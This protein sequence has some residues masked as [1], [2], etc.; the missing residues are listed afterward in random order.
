MEDLQT[1]TL[2]DYGRNQNLESV[3]LDSSRDNENACAGSLLNAC[4]EIDDPLDLMDHCDNESIGSNS[5]VWKG[6]DSEDENDENKE[7]S[8]DSVESSGNVKNDQPTNPTNEITDKQDTSKSET[9]KGNKCDTENMCHKND[10]TEDCVKSTSLIESEEQDETQTLALENES[11]EEEKSSESKNNLNQKENEDIQKTEDS[12]VISEQNDVQDKTLEDIADLEQE[13]SANNSEDKDQLSTDLIETEGAKDPLENDAISKKSLSTDAIDKDSLSPVVTDKD[14]STAVVT[15]KDPLTAVVTDKDPSAAVVTNKDPLAAVVTDKG[16]LAAVVTDKDPLTAVVTDKDPLA[17]VVTNKDPLTAV[18]AD[19]DPLAAVATDKDPLT[20]V[21]TDEDPLS[22][23]ITE[24]DPLST[25]ITERDPLSINIED[26]DS[27]PIDDSNKEPLENKNVDVEGEEQDD[28]SQMDYDNDED[29]DFDPLL[30]CPEVSMAVD[31]SPVVTNNTLTL[32]DAGNDSPLPYEPLF[33]TF[34]DEVTG[35]EISFNL[36]SE[37][38]ELKKRLYGPT[39]PIQITRIHCTACNVHLGSA[40]E[41]QNNRFV[42][43]MLK[44]LICKECYHFYTSGEFE[45]DEDGSEL[46][47]RWCGQG[48]QVLC[49]SK[50]EFVFCKRCIRNNFGRK[51]MFEIRDSDNWDCFRC[52]PLQLI[53]QRIACYEFFEYVRR[54]MSRASTLKSSEIWSTDHSRCCSMKKRALENGEDVKKIKRRKG[55]VDPDYNPHAETSN[56]LSMSPPPL[57]PYPSSS[58]FGGVLGGRTESVLSK[59]VHILPK[60]TVKTKDNDIEFVRQIPAPKVTITAGPRPTFRTILSSNLKTVLQ[61][62]TLVR[63]DASKVPPLIPS[64]SRILGSTLQNRNVNTSSMMKHEWFEKTVR[65]AARVN[66]HLSYT[67]TQLN[68]AQTQAASVEELA[69]VHNKLQEILS[70]SI[71]SLIQI[72]KNLRTEFIAGIK[73]VRLPSKK[74]ESFNNDD[75]VIL[76]SAP[77]T[78]PM[79]STSQVATPARDPIIIIDNATKPIILNAN[80]TSES[81]ERPKSYLKVKSVMELQNVPSECITIP[82]DAPTPPPKSNDIDN[83]SV[84]SDIVCNGANS[85]RKTPESEVLDSLDETSKALKKTANSK[86]TVSHSVSQLKDESPCAEKNEASLKRVNVSSARVFRTRKNKV[87]SRNNVVYNVKHDPPFE[88]KQ[89]MGAYVR[90]TREDLEELKLRLSNGLFVQ[91]K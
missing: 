51:K 63:I 25:D 46:Y 61:P 80:K 13:S 10:P 32:S 47:C 73:T 62:P 58:T 64:G 35:A 36:T 65:A 19:E 30:L 44:V 48:G 54:E 68:K 29:D 37:E 3:N 90:L 72:R 28:E 40:L 1:D 59:P 6:S 45:K 70:S 21:A 16:P 5:D 88:I 87:E 27:A 42:H 43:P 91:K 31:E 74:V 82:D 79:P 71:N 85:E 86:T 11:L 9:D 2:S 77:S 33:S 26:K 39:N 17:A 4:E 84:K 75:D 69:V 22:T 38:Q 56:V 15:D 7:T 81:S 78:M 41:G 50:C 57:T 53:T 12:N 23:D 34:V 8:P 89:M 52:A 14:P 83:E 49:C 24:K 55:E 66:S 67:L 20:A 60:Y 76:V 18:V